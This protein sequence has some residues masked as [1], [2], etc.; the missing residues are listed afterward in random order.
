VNT[1]DLGIIKFEPHPDGQSDVWLAQI[2]ELQ[3]QLVVTTV[4]NGSWVLMGDDNHAICFTA[5]RN[6]ACLAAIDHLIRMGI[7]MVNVAETTPNH[8]TDNE[9]FVEREKMYRN[10]MN[11]LIEVLR[12]GSN[13]LVGL[14][15]RAGDENPATG[16]AED[17]EANTDESEG[18]TIQAEPDQHPNKSES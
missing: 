13:P 11:K 6:A 4:Q 17:S 12:N 18:E 16:P 5:T 15:S 2:D 1:I 10:W 9:R 7:Y 14:I 8:W 3:I